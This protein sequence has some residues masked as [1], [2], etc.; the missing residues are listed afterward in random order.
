M[1]NVDYID[2]TSTAPSTNLESTTYST[3]GNGTTLYVWDSYSCY[4][5]KKP[6][7]E[8][9]PEKIELREWEREMWKERRKWKRTQKYPKWG[10]NR[11]K[12][13]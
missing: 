1:Q 11:P 10:H 13:M 4:E 6:E 5:E 12:H 9:S 7:T 8:E 3:G 2:S